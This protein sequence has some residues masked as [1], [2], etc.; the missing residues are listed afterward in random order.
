MKTSLPECEISKGR[1]SSIACGDP[2][3]DGED[4]R[5]G[6]FAGGC[7][8][9]WGGPVDVDG[10]LGVASGV[11]GT[12]GRT[13][14]KNVSNFGANF[15]ASSFVGSSIATK[16]DGTSVRTGQAA[17]IRRDEASPSEFFLRKLTID[18]N[19]LPGSASFKIGSTISPA[20]PLLNS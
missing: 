1:R 5:V 4:A 11:T 18:L 2:T 10:L 7:V 20:P 12:G 15:A 3:A 6:L 13:V 16:N 17:N 9:R 14:G 19:S 8:A